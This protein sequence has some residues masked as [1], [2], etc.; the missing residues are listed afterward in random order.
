MDYCQ[1]LNYLASTFYKVI[2]SGHLTFEFLTEYIKQNNLKG[3]YVAKV[4][5]YHLRNFMLKEL[6]R[7]KLPDIWTHVSKKMQINIEMITT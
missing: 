1:G 5:E 2:G 6:M 7:A 4:Y 3:M